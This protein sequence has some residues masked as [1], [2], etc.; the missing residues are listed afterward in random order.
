MAPQDFRQKGADIQGFAATPYNAREIGRVKELAEM[1]FDDAAFLGGVERIVTFRPKTKKSDGDAYLKELTHHI[2]ASKET[3]KMMNTKK[4]QLVDACA[5]LETE[6]V[7]EMDT[8]VGAAEASAASMAN[9]LASQAAATNANTQGTAM[10]TA[11]ERAELEAEKRRVQS[12]NQLLEENLRRIEEQEAQLQLGI[13]QLEQ[14]RA[15]I[16]DEEHQKLKASLSKR[17]ADLEQRIVAAEKAE[18]AA[19]RAQDHLAEEK[20]SASHAEAAA[21]EAAALNESLRGE[22]AEVKAELSALT[23]AKDSDAAA[24][25]ASRAE[26]EALSA[27][28]RAQIA[29]LESAASDAAARVE[30]LGASAEAAAQQAQAEMDSLRAQMMHAKDEALNMLE[31]NFGDEIKRKEEEIAAEWAEIMQRK[32]EEQSHEH[33]QE[34]KQRESVHLEQ[35]REARET[36]AKASA[37]SAATLAAVKERAAAREQPA[38]RTA[39]ARDSAGDAPTGGDDSAISDMWRGVLDHSRATRLARSAA[40]HALS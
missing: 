23:F 5:N 7:A 16:R 38:S 11:E 18:A 14:E 4:D 40:T 31:D 17:E 22:L 34:T 26:T 36:A 8:A 37:D 12:Q 21:A 20:K 9:Q 28:L 10:A 24:F 1:I 32:L 30:E 13:D 39:N 3:F 35:L 33:K 2:K 27:D 19:A 29:N 25:E 15:Q 6:L